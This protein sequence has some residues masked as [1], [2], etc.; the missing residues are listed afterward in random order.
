MKKE[1]KKRHYAKEMRDGG[2]FRSERSSVKR[3]LGDSGK[4]A[5]HSG[6]MVKNNDREV[7]DMPQ[8]VHYKPW[9]KG[10]EYF[11]P[12]LDDTITGIDKQMDED[13]MKMKKHLNP[14]KY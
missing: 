14:L 6:A 3:E 2:E 7:A 1:H 11:D 5:T 12:Y 10:G 9:P 4:S 13:G 8:D